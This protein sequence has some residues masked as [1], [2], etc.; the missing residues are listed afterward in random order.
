MRDVIGGHEGGQQM[1]NGTG[2]TTVR[3]ERKRVHPSLS[4]KQQIIKSF[5]Y[6]T[7]DPLFTNTHNLRVIAKQ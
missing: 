1:G 6:T 7:I 5:S 2:L 4:A 3:P